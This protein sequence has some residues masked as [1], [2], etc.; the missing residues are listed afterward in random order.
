M[1]DPRVYRDPDFGA[2]VLLVDREEFPLALALARP[3]KPDPAPRTS[4][5]GA[6][7]FELARVTCEGAER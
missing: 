7:I 1:V 3:A 5:W 2:I 4:V 6:A